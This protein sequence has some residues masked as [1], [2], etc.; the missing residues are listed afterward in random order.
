MLLFLIS[1]L[2]LA[3][4]SWKRNKDKKN[5]QNC[6]SR[7]FYYGILHLPQQNINQG[8][9]QEERNKRKEARNSGYQEAE[10]KENQEAEDEKDQQVGNED[11][12]DLIETSEM[13]HEIKIARLYSFLFLARRMIT[14]LIVVLIPSSPRFFAYKILFLLFLQTAYIL[15]TIFIR[16]FKETKDQV[17]EVLNEFVI[18]TLMFLFIMFYSDEKWTDIVIF[19][20]IGIIL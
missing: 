16:S 12:Q 17:I 13:I 3:L 9:Q 14:I 4:F 15:H 2:L 10:S 19:L 5:I 1:F 7:E 8:R 6:K 18:F 11:S 20:Y